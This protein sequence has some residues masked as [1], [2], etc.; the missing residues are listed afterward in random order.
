MVEGIVLFKCDVNVSEVLV[1]VCE[2]V[3]ELNNG[4]LFKSV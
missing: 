1:K 2:K 4:I 3:M